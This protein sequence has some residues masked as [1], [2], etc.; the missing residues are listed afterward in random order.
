MGRPSAWAKTKPPSCQCSW[1]ALIAVEK[2]AGNQRG[3]EHLA[4]QLADLMD[5]EEVD[6]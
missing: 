4:R 3:A 1:Q 5:G 2:A 6:V